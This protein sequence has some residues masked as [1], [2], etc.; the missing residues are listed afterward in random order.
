MTRHSIEYC[1][2]LEMNWMPRSSR[3]RGRPDL[4]GG[5]L[6]DAD[7]EHLALAD[8][9]G[10]R[11]HRLLERRLGVVAVRLVEVDVVGLETGQRAVDRLHDVLARQAGVVLPTGP[12]RPV[13][14]REDLQALAPLSLERLAEHRLGLGV[15][16]DVGRVERADPVLQG[17]ADALRRDVVLH[18]RAVR[19]PVA[20]GDLGDLQAAVA[21]VSE[22]HAHTVCRVGTSAVTRGG[23]GPRPPS[24]RGDA[25]TSP[26]AA[27]RRRRRT[28]SR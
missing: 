17:R 1:G 6:A 27:S 10:E 20:V 9:V 13:D 24:G 23:A 2:W 3:A 8:E 22:V 11:L 19:E 18:L 7:V 14:L 26:R 28:W 12:G 21:E 16:V 25:G 4:L 5:P 15:R